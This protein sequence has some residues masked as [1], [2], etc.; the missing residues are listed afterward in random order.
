MM[1]LIVTLVFSCFVIP[2]IIS[3]FREKD[4][5]LIWLYLSILIITYVLSVLVG[6]EVKIPSPQPL[7]KSVITT[8]LGSPELP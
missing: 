3:M 2:D 6:L 1:I 8:I 5:H 4:Y 7:I